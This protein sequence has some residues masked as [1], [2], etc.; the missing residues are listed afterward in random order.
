MKYIYFFILFSI[1]QFG[2]QAKRV[3]PKKVQSIVYNNIE[4]SV[5]HSNIGYILIKDKN[6]NT[7]KNIKIYTIEYDND[8]EKDVQDIF[9]INLKI[10]NNNLLITNERNKVYRM[11]LST[12]QITQLSD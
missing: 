10:S 3:A 8:L 4:Y 11:D 2:L 12:Y 1:I 7:I 5:D 6:S 9:I